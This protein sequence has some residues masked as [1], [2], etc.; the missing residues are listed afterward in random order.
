MNIL[1]R[2]SFFTNY[3]QSNLSNEMRELAFTINDSYK[4]PIYLSCAKLTTTAE[5]QPFSQPTVSQLQA[6]L[7]S[8]LD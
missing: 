6:V 8:N 1:S 4:S 3:K 5:Y 2:N 7:S